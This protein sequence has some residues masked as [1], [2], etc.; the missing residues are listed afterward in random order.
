MKSCSFFCIPGAS[1]FHIQWVTDAGVWKGL[2]T[3]SLELRSIPRTLTSS[4][5]DWATSPMWGSLCTYV[6]KE[7]MSLMIF[8]L[9][10]QVSKASGDA[11]VRVFRVY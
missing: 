10:Y 8:K 2:G 1:A 7:E 6:N 3:R 4:H 5:G 11:L 9:F